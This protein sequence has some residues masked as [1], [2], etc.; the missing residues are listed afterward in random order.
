MQALRLTIIKIVSVQ[1]GQ[2]TEG[3]GGP[4]Q[5]AFT[6]EKHVNDLNWYQDKMTG[7]IISTSPVT[8]IRG[9]TGW[10]P[11]DS[12]G[13]H[14]GGGIHGEKICVLMII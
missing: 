10:D 3:A 9:A 6:G 8:C 5:Q 2:E 14:T 1:L 11:G 7:V 13:I 12:P 4:L